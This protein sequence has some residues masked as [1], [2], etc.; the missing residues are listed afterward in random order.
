MKHI[1][2]TFDFETVAVTANAA[3]MQLAA[4][5]WDRT[6]VS[7]PR[8][9]I[10]E[11]HMG[12]DLRS[13]VVSGYDFDQQTVDWWARQK[14]NPKIALLAEKQ[15]RVGTVIREFFKW[16]EDVK[17]ANEATTACL[18]CQGA[19][20]DIPIL[21]NICQ[22]EHIHLPISRDYF[23]DARSFILQSAIVLSFSKNE[24]SPIS[25]D[26]M[27]NPRKIYDWLPSVPLS[28]GNADNAHDALFDCR[29][30]TWNVW[31]IMQ[32]I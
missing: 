17:A 21:K 10:D 19:D 15:E 25:E 16:I 28:F 14:D 1:D 30:T 18:W 9:I 24:T 7:H 22:K 32:M 5:A 11:F 2:I 31:N 23:C 3:P 12:I 8:L 26:F 27:S 4:V 20:F 29:R 6:A 13:C